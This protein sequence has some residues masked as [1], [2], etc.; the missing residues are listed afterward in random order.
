MTSAQDA[1]VQRRRLRNELRQARSAAGYTQTDVAEALEWSPSKLRRIE[2][3][4]V[5][6]SITDLQALLRYY[7]VDDQDEAQRFL[8]LARA[9]KDQPAWW[10][11]YREATSQQYLT[12]LGYESSAS[13]IRMFQP[14]VIPGL[15]QE[16]DYARSIL[17]SSGGSATDKRVEEL[18]E[19]RMR[20]QA[21][22]EREDP[23]ELY[24][25][26]DEAA[27]H[28][29]VGG[30]E[31]MRHQ[32]LRLKKDAQLSNV[33]IEIVPFS[34]GAHPGMKGPFSILEFADDRDG[35]VLFQENPRGDTISRD[36]EEEIQP[37]RLAFDQL[38][39]LA[40]EADPEALI[41]KALR[42]MST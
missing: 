23:P 15:L 8:K 18:V 6:I 24:F 29:W 5:G 16:E 25:V 42:E 36:E 7:G 19:L 30:R 2:S 33:T 27:L 34:A 14:L 38:R 39:E 17:R 28:R 22:L 11:A 21:L 32:L 13:L 35:D 9:G 3:G 20:R 10:R 12:F 37:Y 41:D 1:P 40:G 31:V 26:L 4:T